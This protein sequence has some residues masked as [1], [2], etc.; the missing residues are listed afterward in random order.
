MN[1]PR[2]QVSAIQQTDFD[3]DEADTGQLK[4]SLK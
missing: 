2:D 3:V 1:L 4:A